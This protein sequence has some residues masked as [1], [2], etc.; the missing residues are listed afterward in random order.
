[1]GT[2]Q[3]GLA[4]QCDSR[5]LSLGMDVGAQA[6][7]PV[8]PMGSSDQPTL[9][10]APDPR[11]TRTP[12]PPAGWPAGA[13]R[14]RAAAGVRPGCVKC[15]TSPPSSLGS[16]GAEGAPGLRSAGTFPVPVAGAAASQAGETQARIFLSRLSARVPGVRLLSPGATPL[17]TI[18]G[19]APAGAPLLSWAGRHS[20]PR[21]C[22]GSLLR[23][24]CA[25]G[26]FP[27]LRNSVTRMADG[28]RSSTRGVTLV[29]V[30]AVPGFG[31][32]VGKVQGV[33]QMSHARHP[34]HA[35]GLS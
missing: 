2:G 34:A 13:P 17:R 8:N 12:A 32:P 9:T 19:P 20:V 10:E 28:A 7:G 3:A 23:P 35:A 29:K 5:V 14:P 31:W 4:V 25:L 15:G 21:A 33:G 27:V 24:R 18:D 16:G 26:L 1:M 6:T 30:S 11:P 22:R